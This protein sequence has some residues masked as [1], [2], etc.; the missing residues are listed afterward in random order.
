MTRELNEEWTAY[1]VG[2]LHY[3][4]ISRAE[5]ADRCGYTVPY[6]STVLNCKKQFLSEESKEKTKRHIMDVLNDMEH[7]ILTEERYGNRHHS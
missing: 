3:L 1:V 7:E 4:K 5:F 2:R 6:V